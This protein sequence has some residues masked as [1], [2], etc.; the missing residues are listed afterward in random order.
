M[1]ATVTLIHAVTDA[2]ITI[3]RRDAASR[4]VFRVLDILEINLGIAKK[5]WKA[6]IEIATDN[7][8]APLREPRTDKTPLKAIA[9]LHHA[10]CDGL[11]ALDRERAAKKA[12]IDKRTG[13]I[14]DFKA[15]QRDIMLTKASGDQLTLLSEGDIDGLGYTSAGTRQVLYAALLKLDGDGGLDEHQSDLLADLAG[16]GIDDLD[17]DLDA[18]AAVEDDADEEEA[19]DDDDIPMF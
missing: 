4:A 2:D 1:A 10:A 17:L 9:A 7:M 15:A 8:E 3:V 18:G 19:D 5:A 16:A 12:D 11:A 13:K 6:K 14:A